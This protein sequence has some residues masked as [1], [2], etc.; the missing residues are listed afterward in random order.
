MG[1]AAGLAH[2]GTGFQERDFAGGQAA[3]MDE[4]LAQ[5]AAGPAAG[6]KRF[7]TVEGFVADLAIPGLNPQQHGL[8]RSAAFSDTHALEYSEAIGG[9]TRRISELRSQT[10]TSETNPVN[11]HRSVERR[12]SC[13]S[14]ITRTPMENSPFPSLGGNQSYPLLRTSN[15]IHAPSKLACFS[16]LG[17]A[18]V[19]VPLRPSN[20]HILIV[21]VPGARDQH[22]CH[23]LPFC[24]TASRPFVTLRAD[25]RHSPNKTEI[26]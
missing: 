9:K 14:P 6:K 4:L 15:D 11:M 17:M 7:V 25:W 24:L 23:S 10:M 12:H 26:S 18:P 1:G 20:E 8:P 5:A 2:A 22:G 3:V 16:Y 21:R 19:L 13:R